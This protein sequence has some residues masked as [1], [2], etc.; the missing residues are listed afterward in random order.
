MWWS[1]TTMTTAGYGDRYPVTSEGRLIA[2]VLMAGGV[3]V[4]GTLSG[5]VAGWFLSPDTKQADADRDEL[6]VLLEQLR[7]QRAAHAAAADRVL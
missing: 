5:L 2:V 6:K 7:D 4:F 1:V 3:G